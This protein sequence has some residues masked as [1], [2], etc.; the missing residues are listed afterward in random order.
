M[1][2]QVLV[3][4]HLTKEIV[5]ESVGNTC[6]TRFSLASQRDYVDKKTNKRETDFVPVVVWG[7]GAEYLRDHANTKTVVLIKGRFTVESYTDKN[8]NKSYSQYVLAERYGGVEILANGVFESSN[9]AAQPSTQ[10]S[11]DD[12]GE[13]ADVDISNED[14]PY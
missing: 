14:L 9:N 6:K 13:Y 1:L 8:G 2:N 5:V 11:F 4:G 7:Q 10:S 3:V 12:F